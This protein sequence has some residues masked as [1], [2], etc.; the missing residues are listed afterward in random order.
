MLPLFDS[1]GVKEYITTVPHVSE[2]I[3]IAVF[4]FLATT[5][6][7][8]GANC[9]KWQPKSTVI[10]EGSHYNFCVLVEFKASGPGC[11]HFGKEILSFYVSRF[12]KKMDTCMSKKNM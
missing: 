2:L 5:C 1:R 11:S 12:L 9:W 6:C 3:Y 10:A 7:G 4:K 8:F